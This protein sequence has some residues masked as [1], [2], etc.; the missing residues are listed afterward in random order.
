[1][2]N[3]ATGKP[4]S[5]ER[6]KQNNQKAVK[7]Y[8]A[9]RDAITLRPSIEDGLKLRSAAAFCG[10]SVQAFVMETMLE[11]IDTEHLFENENKA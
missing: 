6:K 2:P 8:Q 5:E 9:K 7:R 11:K 1:M 4:D 10:K 3:K